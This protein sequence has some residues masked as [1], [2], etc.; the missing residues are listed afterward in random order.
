MNAARARA[1]RLR[2]V[3]V[4]ASSAAVAVAAHSVGGADLPAA[5]AIVLLVLACA[6]L[7]AAASSPAENQRCLP[8][9]LAY[10][11]AGQL[12]GHCALVFASTH[13]HA[14][15]WSVPMLAS[16]VVSALSCAALICTVER[17]SGAL[18]GVLWRLILVLQAL[19]DGDQPRMSRP[20]WWHCGLAS[21]ILARCGPGT[22]GPPLVA[23]AA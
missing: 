6:A 13:A 16:H 8:V 23:S 14:D 11:S 21:R 10:V 9:V 7:G 4:G 22:R 12:V 3:L 2:G 18:A 1:A 20:V 15:H 19:V 5:P 17:L